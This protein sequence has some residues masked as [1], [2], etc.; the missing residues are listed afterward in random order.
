MRK[1]SAKKLSEQVDQWNRTVPPWSEVEF[2]PVIG[3][4]RYRLDRTRSEAQIL[5]GHTAV[6]WLEKT[7]GCVA[8]DACVPIVQRTANEQ[9]PCP[10]APAGGNEKEK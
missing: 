8:L 3:E 7:P 10:Q 5:G 1:P 2:H 6:V 9:P 4:A